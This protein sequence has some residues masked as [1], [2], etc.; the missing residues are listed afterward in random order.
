[1]ITIKEVKDPWFS[2]RQNL[3][4]N[5]EPTVEL[6]GMMCMWEEEKKLRSFLKAMSEV[7]ITTD[8]PLPMMPDRIPGFVAS[9]S[10][11][12]EKNAEGQA[13]LT[14]NLLK[15]KPIPHTG[16]LEFMVWAWRIT[17]ITK[18]CMTQ[19][20]RHRIA[21]FVQLSG[22]Y[23]DRS[24]TGFVYNNWDYL[25]EEVAKKALAIEEEHN[26]FSD[27]KY[28]NL[29][30][31]GATKQD[32]RKRLPVAMATGTYV[33]MNTVAIRNFFSLRL[34]SHAEWEIRRMGKRMYDTC[35][36][37]APAQF[38]KLIEGTE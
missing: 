19:F 31:L 25:E 5:V 38:I 11:A 1:M 16:P 36:D 33:Y 2:L 14:K 18:S 23:I 8:T 17:G 9:M 12:S 4:K 15:M 30:A 34:D 35:L 21:G 29:K 3:Y 20:D 7:A 10:H 37:V 27:W 32:A 22:R 6:V 13:I 26:K 24:K 28:E